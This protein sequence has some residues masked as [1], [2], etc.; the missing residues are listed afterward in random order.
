[1]TIVVNGEKREI[2]ENARI[3]DLLRDLSLATAACAV[4]VNKKLI[5]KLQHVSQPLANG[6]Q[7]EIVTLV[8]GG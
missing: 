3:P 5:P 4:E 6:D 1:M 2:A 8:G 7:I